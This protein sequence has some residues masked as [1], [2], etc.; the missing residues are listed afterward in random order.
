MD[1]NPMTKAEVRSWLKRVRE[2]LRDAETALANND[3]ESLFLY[4]QDAAASAASVEGACVT[5]G[6]RGLGIYDN[7]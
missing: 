3:L 2:D 6:I 7:A 1:D 5:E 4:A